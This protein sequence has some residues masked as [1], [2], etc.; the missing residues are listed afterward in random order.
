MAFKQRWIKFSLLASLVLAGCGFHLQGTLMIPQSLHTLYF[1]SND[2]YGQF[3]QQFRQSL[4]NATVNLVSNA[5]QAP[6]TLAILGTNQSTQQ[7]GTGQSQ[8]TR[9]FNLIYT[10]TF[11][12]QDPNGANIYGPT[13]VTATQNF[14]LAPEVLVED[15][16]QLP[17]LVQ[18][19]QASAMQSILDKLDS[20]Q[21][22][23]ALDQHKTQ[24]NT[25]AAHENQ[26][27][28]AENKTDQQ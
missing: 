9:V 7:V 5:S 27:K 21:V 6:Y 3:S 24:T 12:L 20:T 13:T 8:Q 15:S 14:S 22:Q 18:Q 4:Q 23:Q 10:V 17:T 25:T 11:S 1:T 19:A 26:S 16:P 2:P 28:P